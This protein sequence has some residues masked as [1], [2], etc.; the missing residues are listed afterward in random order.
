MLLK[1][2]REMSVA[3]FDIAVSLFRHKHLLAQMMRQEIRGRFAG[4]IGGMVWNLFHPF[5]QALV[6]VFV[7]VFVFHLRIDSSLQSGTSVVYILAGLFPWLLIADGIA[8]GTAAPFENA[9]MIQK[10]AFPIEVIIA[11]SIIMPIFSHG[12]V[13][14]LLVAYQV[15]LNGSISIIFPLL[16]AL[17]LQGVF[18]LGVAFLTSTISVYFRDFIQLVTVFI[19][20]GIFMTPIFYHLSMVPDWVRGAMNFNPFFAYIYVWQSVI[21]NGIDGSLHILLQASSWAIGVI[22]VGAFVFN[23]LKTEFVDWL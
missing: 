15:V 13:L 17:V 12:F 8:K 10:S 2:G 21:L 16:L 14:L 20:I 22:F 3:P 6:Y 7:F 9:H 1:Y 11:K 4:T 19:A 18:T 23:K 5:V